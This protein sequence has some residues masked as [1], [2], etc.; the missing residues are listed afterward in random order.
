[1]KR[2]LN[3]AIL[4]LTVATSVQARAWGIHTQMEWK[5]YRGALLSTKVL[6]N[7]KID[8]CV[9]LAPD[10]LTV[11]NSIIQQI[12]AGLSMWINPVVKSLN[13]TVEVDSVPCGDPR[14][15][16]KVVVGHF[17]DMPS[18]GRT[19]YLIT[20]SEPAELVRINLDAPVQNTR[21]NRL[22]KPKDFVFFLPPNVELEKML[23]FLIGAPT[24]SIDL[25]AQKYLNTNQS[26]N[27]DD[28][29]DSTLSI[30]LHELGHS[31][32][33][34]HTYDISH[35]SKGNMLDVPAVQQ[36]SS[37]M[38]SGDYLNLTADDTAGV[39]RLFELARAHLAE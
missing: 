39:M 27:V 7:H 8:Y 29:N 26:L 32:G 23:D 13:H 15:D 19:S 38:K 22:I 6:K 16:L 12:D 1:M 31:L 36:P 4:I 14:M 2:I 28:L 25:Y 35:C 30:L 17:P 21:D 10:Y 33:L 11:P 20:S 18:G 24:M 3:L 9:E 34:C 37:L 5:E